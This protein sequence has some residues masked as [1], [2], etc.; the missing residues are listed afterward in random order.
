M[1]DIYIELYCLLQTKKEIHRVSIFEDT[2]E[3][4]NMY[5]YI[6]Y[7]YISYDA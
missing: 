2:M 3:S 1:Q 5:I 7:M 4:L 6:V